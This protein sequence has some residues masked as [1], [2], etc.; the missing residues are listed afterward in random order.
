MLSSGGGVNIRDKVSCPNLLGVGV[1]FIVDGSG[2]N[3]F[4]EMVATENM[5]CVV[6]GIL[7]LFI[8]ITKQNLPVCNGVNV[9][10][11]AMDRENVSDHLLCGAKCA[12]QV[13]KQGPTLQKT[14]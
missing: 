8:S 11:P 7:N 1:L 3:A 14:E 13:S 10:C 4:H 9:G 5:I 6:I 12:L 2:S